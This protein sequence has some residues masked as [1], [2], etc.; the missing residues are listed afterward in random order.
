MIVCVDDLKAAARRR[1]PRFVFDYVEGGA[2]DEITVRR[3]R[4]GFGRYA[5]LPRVFT[6]VSARDTSCVVLGERLPFPVIVAPTGLLGMIRPGAEAMI[7]RAAAHHGIPFAVSSMSSLSLEQI[8]AAVPPSSKLWFQMYIWR[9]RGLTREVAARARAAGYRALCLTLDVQVLGSRER[10]HLHGFFTVPSRVTV[11][12][13][14]QA[15]SR[16]AWLAALARGPLP[17]FGNFAG[18]AGAGT[19]PQSLGT[20]AT[21][22]LDPSVTWKDLD[23]LRSVWDGALVVKGLLNADDARLAVAHGA[24]AVVVSNHGGRQLDGAAGAI[25]ALPAVVDAVAGRTDVI[26]DG[27]IRRGRD[28]VIAV[29]LGATACMAGRPFV[30]GAAAYGERGA[31]LAMDILRND[32]DR[33]LALLGVSRLSALDSSALTTLE[34]PELATAS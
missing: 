6:D 1:L 19:T 22:Q 32:T 27:G 34:T 18:V 20:F 10:D 3:N 29:A 28:V 16:P 30:Y 11:R 13:I 2:G 17:T 12:A 23:W 21:S 14:L 4:N 24:D 8:A 5:L 33:T 9:D 26:L 15:M 25:D 31:G 7:A